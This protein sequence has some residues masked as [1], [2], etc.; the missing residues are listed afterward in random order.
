MARVRLVWLLGD[1]PLDEL[2]VI[3]LED[4]GRHG[5]TV[6]EL[7]TDAARWEALQ[8]GLRTRALEGMQ[9][10]PLEQ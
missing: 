9:V 4:L 1:P 5:L 7:E 2:M 10:I 3:Y 6:A 8:D